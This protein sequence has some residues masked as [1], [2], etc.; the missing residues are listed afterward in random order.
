[1]PEKS[2]GMLFWLANSVPAHSITK[3]LLGIIGIYLLR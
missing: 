3:I 2:P 1:M